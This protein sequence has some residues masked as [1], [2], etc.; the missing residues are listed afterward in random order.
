MQEATISR[1]RQEG[2]EG[3]VEGFAF[4]AY[5]STER[6]RLSLKNLRKTRLLVESRQSVTW[7]NIGIVSGHQDV[8]EHEHEQGQ[9]ARR[10][11]HGPRKADRQT[12]TDSDPKQPRAASPHTKKKNSIDRLILP[13]TNLTQTRARRKRRKSDSADPPIP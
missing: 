7:Q 4:G 11:R 10:R 3:R 1:G 2:R 9:T 6:A 13:I 12:S 5:H 8:H